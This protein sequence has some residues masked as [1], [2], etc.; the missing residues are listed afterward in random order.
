MTKPRRLAAIVAA[1]LLLAGVGWFLWT[2]FRPRLYGSIGEYMQSLAKRREAVGAVLGRGGPLADGK[3]DMDQLAQTAQDIFV[4]F[5][6]DARSNDP[7]FAAAATALL[8]EAALLERTWDS[9]KPTDAGQ[10]FA[11]MTRAC[12]ECHAAVS[13]GKGPRLR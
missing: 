6:D 13:N 10:A 5:V 7:R 3:P 1:L 12:N 9:G 11:A 4:V 8:R 2:H